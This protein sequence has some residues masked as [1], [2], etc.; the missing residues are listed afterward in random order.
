MKRY[1]LSYLASAYTHKSKK[2]MEE[3]YKAVSRIGGLL[4]KKEVHN[5]AVISESH[6]VAKY[7]KV[8]G[9][10]TWVH[11]RNR[12]A[13]VLLRC[14]QLLICDFDGW[15]KSIGIKNEILLAY[16]LRM[17]IKM[18]NKKGDLYPFKMSYMKNV[19]YTKEETKWAAKFIE[20]NHKDEEEVVL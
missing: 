4:F 10:T 8:L 14:D 6:S 16:I 9:D 15:D 3:R 12:D 19:G 2:I 13:N 1:K 5:I 17:P 20:N 11:W 7:S 18:V